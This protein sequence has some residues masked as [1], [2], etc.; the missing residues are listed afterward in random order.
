VVRELILAEALRITSRAQNDT[1]NNEAIDTLIQTGCLLLRT[2]CGPGS[3]VG[4]YM[5]VR[6]IASGVSY[7]HY[8]S[9]WRST[10]IDSGNEHFENSDFLKFCASNG[11]RF[12]IPTGQRSQLPKTMLRYF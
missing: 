9:P 4:L 12:P 7:L 2:S 8:P 11:G 6:P 10:E 3:N 5:H 1:F